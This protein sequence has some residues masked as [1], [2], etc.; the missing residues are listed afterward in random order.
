MKKTG[1]KSTSKESKIDKPKK[2]KKREVKAKTK[3]IEKK[4]VQFNEEQNEIV[5]DT[6]HERKWN[7]YKANKANLV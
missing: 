3:E 5:L 6:S 1:V 7:D 4:K 2:D